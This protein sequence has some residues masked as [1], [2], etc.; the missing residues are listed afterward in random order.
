[1]FGLKSSFGVQLPTPA[2]K[3]GTIDHG[4]GRE[5]LAHASRASARRQLRLLRANYSG[6]QAGGAQPQKRGALAQKASGIKSFS[7]PIPL[8]LRLKRRGN[9]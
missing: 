7:P 6:L 3:G 2:L 4:L 8:Y 9:S 5:R 1:M